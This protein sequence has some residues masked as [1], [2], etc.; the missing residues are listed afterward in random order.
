MEQLLNEDQV[1]QIEI[2][3]EE[4]KKN[5]LNESFLAM[6]GG[7]IKMILDRMFSTGTPHYSGFYKVKGSRRDVTAFART[8]GSEKKYLEAASQYGLDNPK[9]YKSKKV[10]D[11]AITGFE[12]STGLKWPFK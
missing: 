2:D 12:K 3:L 4:L 8:L 9:T 1:V 11:K 6:F 10:L 5:E 7:A